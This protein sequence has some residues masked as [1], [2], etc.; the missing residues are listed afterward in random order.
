M[1]S[2]PW[3]SVGPHDVFPEEFGTFLLG[4]PEQLVPAEGGEDFL[5][6]AIRGFA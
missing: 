4:D 5:P 6:V 1:S 3:Y 2:E